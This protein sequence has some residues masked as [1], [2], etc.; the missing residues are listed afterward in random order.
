VGEG[1]AGGG[2]TLTMHRLGLS[3][4]HSRE[5]SLSCGAEIDFPN[6]NVCPGPFPNRITQAV[7]DWFSSYTSTSMHISVS[8]C[9]TFA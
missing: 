3:P 7:D 1:F 4:A 8:P 6:P 5:A 9:R 2:F